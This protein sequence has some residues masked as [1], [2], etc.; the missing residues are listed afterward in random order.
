MSL[1]FTAFR[2]D[3][4]LISAV[5]K[6]KNHGGK[7]HFATSRREGQDDFKGGQS[8]KNKMKEKKKK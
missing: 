7:W 4:L 8:C 3:I 2:V 1:C 5:F 6:V